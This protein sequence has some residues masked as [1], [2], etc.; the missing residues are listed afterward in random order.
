MGNIWQLQEA[1]NRF[2]SLVKK[3]L[4]EG[5][6]IVTRHGKESVVVLDIEAYKKLSK[7]KEDLVTF[8]RASPLRGEKL[9]LDR[10]KSLAREIKI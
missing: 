9:D 5:P 10:N 7:P 8:L 4:C 1:K 2:S 3:A 6:Q